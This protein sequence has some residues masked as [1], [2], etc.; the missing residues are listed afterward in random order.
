MSARRIR[1]QPSRSVFLRGLLPIRKRRRRSAP[2]LFTAQWRRLRPS[3]RFGTRA[4]RSL[5]SGGENAFASARRF[6]VPRCLGGPDWKSCSSLAGMPPAF[7]NRASSVRGSRSLRYVCSL[8]RKR[9]MSRSWLSF[10]S[11]RVAEPLRPRLRK[12]PKNSLSKLIPHLA[13]IH[14]DRLPRGKMG[15]ALGTDKAKYRHL[16]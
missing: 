4:G 9:P 1:R 7:G 8:S 6:V 10:K 16:P 14:A 12:M 3:Y 5:F 13:F 15:I 2:F 11:S